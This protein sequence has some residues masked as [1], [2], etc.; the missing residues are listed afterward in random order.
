[1]AWG[2]LWAYIGPEVVMPLLSFLAAVFGVILIGWQWIVHFVSGCVRR[3][4]G[5]PKPSLSGAA[6]TA[7]QQD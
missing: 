2:N 1:M 5:G 6:E 7:G 3:L 4:F